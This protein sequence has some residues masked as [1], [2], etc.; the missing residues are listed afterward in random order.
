MKAPLQIRR[1]WHKDSNAT[2][3]PFLARHKL[4]VFDSAPRNP[5]ARRQTNR[6]SLGRRGSRGGGSQAD[7]KGDGMELFVAFSQSHC[8]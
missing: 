8:C 6:K 3:V 5:S 1:H 4:S 7:S 2:E